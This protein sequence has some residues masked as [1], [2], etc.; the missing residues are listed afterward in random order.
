MIA[1]LPLV[2]LFLHLLCL[3]LDFGA[4]AKTDSRPCVFPAAILAAG[5]LSLL[6]QRK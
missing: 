1:L 3:V 4:V 5:S 2:H 6:A